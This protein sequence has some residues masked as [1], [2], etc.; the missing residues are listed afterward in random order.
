MSVGE[1][2]DE[3]F[4]ALVNG[5]PLVFSLPQVQSEESPDEAAART[6]PAS[7]LELVCEQNGGKFKHPLL[8]SGAILTGPLSVQKAIFEQALWFTD[9]EF[10]D[11]VD[12]SFATFERVV[13][14]ERPL[15][16]GDFAC[17][18]ANF[19]DNVLF[20]GGKFKR[21][22]TFVYIRTE[23]DVIFKS[24]G[25]GKRVSFEKDATFTGANISKTIQFEGVSFHGDLR[26][27][28]VQAENTKF[29][30]DSH[31]NRVDCSGSGN[32]AGTNVAGTLS[33]EGAHF[34]RSA[35]FTGIVANV[36][37]LVHDQHRNRVVIEGPTVLTK[38]DLGVLY[39]DAVE[40]RD[41]AEFVGIRVAQNAYFRC[42]QPG[43][44]VVFSQIA[45]FTS[46][47]FKQDVLFEGTE[48]KGDAEFLC[49]KIGGNASFLCK[50]R[51]PVAFRGKLN[52]VNGVITDSLQF[53]GTQFQRGAQFSGLQV[54]GSTI[55]YS[56]TGPNIV[57]AG[58]A[59]FQGARTGDFS[60]HGVE[61]KG[62]ANFFGVETNG[63]GFHEDGEHRSLFHG[64][65]EFSGIT[66]KGP[67]Y[68]ENATF[69]RG[70][71]FRV[72]RLIGGASF[73][74][75][76]FAHEADFNNAELG[77]VNFQNTTFGS[78]ARFEHVRFNGL[79]DFRAGEFSANA[80]FTHSKIERDADFSSC[81]F[82]ANADFKAVV[83]V[84]QITFLLAQFDGPVSFRDAHFTVVIFAEP[85]NLQGGS[86][87]WAFRKRLL[88]GRATI[89][90]D[91]DLIGCAYE[92]IYIE[93]SDLLPRLKPFDR[94]PYSQ[95]ESTLRKS[96]D[97][98]RCHEVYLERR[99]VERKQ[100]LALRT[101]HLWLFDWLYKLGANYG[102][103]PFR[104][105]AYAASLI[106]LGTWIFAQ[107]GALALKQMDQ[108][109]GTGKAPG[110]AQAIDVSIHYFLPMD[111]PIGATWIPRSEAVL[112]TIAI[113]KTPV[114]VAIRPDR[115]ATFI[116][117]AGSVI[118]G[119]C[120]AA[121]TGLLRRVAP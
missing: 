115:Y 38:S 20:S 88:L 77:D 6:I 48:F 16:D 32:F 45:Q 113:P 89:V 62:S 44:P 33:I 7:W 94:Q 108:Q 41:N 63:V 35:D 98:A 27:D 24:D 97:D 11:K 58:A 15:F 96:G 69:C 19:K 8:I 74:G 25:G 52:L 72:A 95:L 105:V 116:R 40:F 68:F 36:V 103:R 30:S 61:F 9:C 54:G 112:I 26:F 87:R 14:F 5:Q 57:F 28:L 91:V 114:T 23:R 31:K 86:E 21:T 46:A 56:G 104:L 93:L 85:S 84:H 65:A 80:I 18:G 42:E 47:E 53:E 17:V 82:G 100:R 13:R 51:T 117:V 22:A 78:D 90:G 83:V 99:R 37:R 67:A 101:I 76:N 109:T 71:S 3:R 70:V 49:V 4:L 66:S 50:E 119:V 79:L 111:S 106:A 110:F 12:V 55:F 1:S 34:S 59:D 60:F 107:P 118:V 102:V 75:A 2:F 10:T 39:C 81:R 121:L 92:R 73:K 29:N 64:A 120:L 43:T